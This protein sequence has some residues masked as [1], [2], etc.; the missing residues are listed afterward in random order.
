MPMKR[1]AKKDREA[2]RRVGFL[3][4]DDGK[5]YKRIKSFGTC[6][7]ASAF[8]GQQEKSGKDVRMWSEQSGRF[9]VGELIKVSRKESK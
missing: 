3:T 7:A 9:A 2:E 5:R 8:L 4:Y 6:E 1:S